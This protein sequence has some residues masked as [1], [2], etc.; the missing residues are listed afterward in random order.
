MLW[1]NSKS[2]EWYSVKRRRNT[3][4]NQ[5]T[6]LHPVIPNSSPA[7]FPLHKHTTQ[8]NRNWFPTPS[9]EKWL[10]FL[11][12]ENCLG[13][14]A[15]N[16]CWSRLGLIY[17][18]YSALSGISRLSNACLACCWIFWYPTL[19]PSHIIPSE[20]IW[21]HTNDTWLL[22][23]HIP[24]TPG[25]VLKF[26]NGWLGIL[27]PFSCFNQLYLNPEGEQTNKCQNSDLYKDRS[28]IKKSYLL[29]LPS[30]T[31]QCRDSGFAQ[32]ESEVTAWS[33]QPVCCTFS[34]QISW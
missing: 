22:I 17:T 21:T 10:V 13:N 4:W 6:R 32:T 20:S 12:F 28:I 2:R 7:L 1:Q 24:F 33:L 29:P 25:W 19:P 11:W 23:I 3:P 27:N 26:F 34:T 5:R 18:K 8:S 16:F 15:I 30:L 9:W 14:G 31:M